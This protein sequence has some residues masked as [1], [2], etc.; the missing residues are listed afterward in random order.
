MLKLIYSVCVLGL[1]SNTLSA[2]DI[3]GLW[4][5]TLYNDSNQLVYNYEIAITNNNGKLGGYSHTWFILDQN[6]YYGVKKVK[7]LQRPELILIE[8]DGLIAN[9]Y[10][11]KPAKGVRQL[12]RLQFKDSAGISM[13]FGPYETNRIKQY[14]PLTGYIHLTRVENDQKNSLIPHLQELNLA[15][16]LSFL[17]ETMKQP[18]ARSSKTAPA[19]ILTVAER[20]DVVQH[21]SLFTSDSLHFTL[22]DNGEV[23]GDSVSVFIDGSAILSKQRLSTEPVKLSISTKGK[24]ELRIVMYAES[25]GTIPPNTGLLIVQDGVRKQEVRFSGNLTQNAVLI[26]RKEPAGN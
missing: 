12:N 14:A 7:V 19:K 22:Y 1:L 26:F 13:L 16:N 5:G 23:D 20:E 8:D 4:K 15:Q 18:V 2:Q 24:D 10:P 3:T 11:V 25:L 17:P 21:T 9:N 6:Q